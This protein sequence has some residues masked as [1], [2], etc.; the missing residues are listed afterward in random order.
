M[1]LLFEEHP[2]LCPSY[3]LY[4]RVDVEELHISIVKAKEGQ[5]CHGE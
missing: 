3:T 2:I 4:L 1:L 5:Y